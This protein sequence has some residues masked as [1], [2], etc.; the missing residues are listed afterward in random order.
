MTVR[1]VTLNPEPRGLAADDAALSARLE[2]EAGATGR[3]LAVKVDGSTVLT[4]SGGSP[5]VSGGFGGSVVLDGTTLDVEVTKVGGW[6]HGT[7]VTWSVSYYDSVTASE[8]FEGSFA[9]VGVTIVRTSPVAG[10]SG[11]ARRPDIYVEATPDAGTP[12]GVD[13]AVGGE[14]AILSAVVQTPAFEGRAGVAGSNGYGVVRPRRAFAWGARVDVIS[15]PVVSV[16]GTAYWGR[17]AF[18]FTTTP[19]PTRATSEQDT[20]PFE[21]PVCETVRQLAAS[22][23]R[24]D[25]GSPSLAQVAAFYMRRTEVGGLVP[26]PPDNAA[27][28]DSIDIPHWDTLT[29][30]VKHIEPLWRALLAGAPP[31][32]HEALGRAWASGHVAERVGAICVI[33]T[34]RS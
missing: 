30:F 23:L 29:A 18:T 26:L 24:P 8:S 7:A 34:S 4:W 9:L 28:L 22:A 20:Q 3:S 17:H 31:E 12:I 10:G 25:G 13:L 15:R 33:L 21:D 19:R 27:E 16:S 2:V 5:T 6:A 11:A 32:F 14:A 1:L